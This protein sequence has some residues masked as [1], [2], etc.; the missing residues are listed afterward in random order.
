MPRLCVAL[1]SALPGWG[2]VTPFTL[3]STSQYWLPGPPALTS[4]RYARDFNEVKNVGGKVR[5]LLAGGPGER[6]VARLRRDPLPF[7]VRR[8]ARPGP[9][10]RR[11]RRDP[12]SLAFLGLLGIAR[13]L[14][15]WVST[16]PAPAL[17]AERARVIGCIL[18]VTT[19]LLLIGHGGFDVAMHNDWRSLTG[20][21]WPFSISW[22][23]LSHARPSRQEAR[24][25]SHAKRTPC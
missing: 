3:L 5:E 9:K 16:R 13:S 4:E 19:A 14:R 10:D 21:V 8:R 22:R 20:E 7:R 1:P 25:C 15:D 12:P 18:R 11:A 23:I 17:T 24:A 2:D 6:G